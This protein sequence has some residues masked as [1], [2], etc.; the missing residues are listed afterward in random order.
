M[1]ATGK[2]GLFEM[3]Q[4]LVVL[5]VVTIPS[6]QSSALCTICQGAIGMA[7]SQMNDPED[8][9]KSIKTVLCPR[10]PKKAVALCK[11]NASIISKIIA[12][13][14]SVA[15]PRSICSVLHICSNSTDDESS[16]DVFTTFA[17][18]ETAVPLNTTTSPE[19][20]PSITQTTIETS[21]TD[22]SSSAPTATTM[23][24]YPSVSIEVY[25]SKEECTLCQYA[26]DKIIR[27]TAIEEMKPASFVF[28]RIQKACNA[29]PEN[30]APIL[31]QQCK[32]VL[33]T[34]QED[35][36]YADPVALLLL[37]PV[38]CFETKVCRDDDSV[39]IDEQHVQDTCLTFVSKP[40]REAVNESVKDQTPNKF[41][42]MCELYPKAF[43]LSDTD[44]VVSSCLLKM[45]QMDREHL[46][47]SEIEKLTTSL[48]VSICE[49]MAT[50][51][52]QLIE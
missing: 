7:I 28:Q 4:F 18:S 2:L 36:K 47:E 5:L 20:D 11:A 21:A 33:S 45:L 8:L 24:P 39:D 52:Q 44:N 48:S 51:V 29:L 26:I 22:V 43:E 3:I 31:K 50:Q 35:G 14:E 19:Q 10:L 27:K 15:V 37:P 38:F 25:Y 41:L 1:L 16:T 13:G 30:V 17:P 9:E 32:A 12:L 40:V 23:A 6:V 34:E 46:K 42:K 49:K